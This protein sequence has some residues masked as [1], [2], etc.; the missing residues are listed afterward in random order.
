MDNWGNNLNKFNSNNNSNIPTQNQ[1]RFN[2]QQIQNIPENNFSDYDNDDSH[3]NNNIVNHQM[4]MKAY[5]M[6]SYKQN[7]HD[8]DNENDLEQ[9]GENENNEM[10]NS[11]YL[12]NSNSEGHY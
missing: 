11:A 3:N 5:Q 8:N 10:I 12:Q 1:G 7:N 4:N 9:E 6:N 2:N